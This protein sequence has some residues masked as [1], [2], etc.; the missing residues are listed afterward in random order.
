[1]H[2]YLLQPETGESSPP[3]PLNTRPAVPWVTYPSHDHFSLYPLIPTSL[4]RLFK[5][6]PNSSSCFRTHQWSCQNMSHSIRHAFAQ[7]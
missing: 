6:S 1:M 2:T 7:N 4:A 3:G 5:E